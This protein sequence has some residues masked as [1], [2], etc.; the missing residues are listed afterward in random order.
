M[1][2]VGVEELERRLRELPRP[3]ARVE[4]RARLKA[5]FSR[6]ASPLPA[7]RR[8]V[9]TIPALLTAAAAF[10]AVFFLRVGSAA[11]GWHAVGDAHAAHVWI[12]SEELSLEGRERLD[13][14]MRCGGC[15]LR[16]D[17]ACAYFARGHELLVCCCA[18]SRV[19]TLDPSSEGTLEVLRYEL[20]EGGLV[21]S[22]SPSFRGILRV[23]TRFGE[24]ELAGEAVAVRIV[25]GGLCI[26]CLD[27]RAVVRGGERN[28]VVPS[29]HSL[30]LPD[31][32]SP[33]R[34]GELVHREALTEAQRVARASL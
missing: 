1:K 7:R 34:E 23:E 18:R 26:C 33:P 29:N 15:E 28:F 27:G 8:R 30:F 32:G 12:G 31:D 20:R 11:P 2:L 3:R 16:A 9:R 17:D 24:I 4:F 10:L 22:T 5:E 25:D 14:A 19:V 21:A 6:A 13:R